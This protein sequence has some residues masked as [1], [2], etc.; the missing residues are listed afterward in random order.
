MSAVTSAIDVRDTV[1]VAGQVAHRFGVRLAE[2]PSV[3]HLRQTIITTTVQ[4]LGGS[5][6]ECYCVYIGFM[7]IY[8]QYT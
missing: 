1:H 2:C 4:D 3:P 5:V 7:S 6:R 8:L